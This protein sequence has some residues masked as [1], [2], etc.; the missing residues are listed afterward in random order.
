MSELS[1]LAAFKANNKGSGFKVGC[2]PG[3]EASK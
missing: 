2:V 3:N 1:A